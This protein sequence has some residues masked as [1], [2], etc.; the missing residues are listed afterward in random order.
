M[1]SVTVPE[2]RVSGIAGPVEKTRRIGSVRRLLKR[3]LSPA[4]TSTW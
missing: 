1:R 4:A 3:S 2:A